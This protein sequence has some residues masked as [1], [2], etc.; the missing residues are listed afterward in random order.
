MNWFRHAID[1]VR[2]S[3]VVAD[4]YAQKAERDRFFAFYVSSAFAASGLLGLIGYSYSGQLLVASAI[5]PIAALVLVPA[6]ALIA[7][8]AWKQRLIVRHPGVPIAEYINLRELA[9]DEYCQALHAIAMARL[10]KQDE[11]LVRKAALEDYLAFCRELRRVLPTGQLP[12]PVAI[13]RPQL[14]PP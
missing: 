10:P 11:A 13:R 9:Y 14:P 12:A 4:I 6:G 3:L 1:R 2:K 7:A 8:H 5:A